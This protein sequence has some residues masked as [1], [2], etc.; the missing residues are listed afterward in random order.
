M[1]DKSKKEEK[2]L[3]S[4]SITG[5]V[6]FRY[7]GGDNVMVS[8]NFSDLDHLISWAERIKSEKDEVLKDN[9]NYGRENN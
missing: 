3:E 7:K 4:I 2:K 9:E 5:M 1:F 8:L 6:T